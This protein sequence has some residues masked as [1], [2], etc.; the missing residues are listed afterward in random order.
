V[1]P[2]ISGPYQKS[3]LQRSFA[4]PSETNGWLRIIQNV[5]DALRRFEDWRSTRTGQDRIPAHLWRAAV[6]LPDRGWL[7]VD[8]KGLIGERTYDVAN[9]LGNPWPH[10]AIVHSTERMRRMAELYANRLDMDC[11]RVL[12]FALAHAGLAASWDFDDGSDPDY[13]LKCVEVLAPLVAIS[14]LRP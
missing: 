1:R 11:H 2:W 3:K 4:K 12:A 14:S 5:F 8:P 10:G 7:A 6:R 9:L 13:R